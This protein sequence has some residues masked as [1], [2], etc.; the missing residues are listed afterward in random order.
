LK[1]SREE[2]QYGKED[3]GRETWRLMIRRRRHQKNKPGLFN[4]SI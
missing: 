1:I 2:K 4:L 3:I